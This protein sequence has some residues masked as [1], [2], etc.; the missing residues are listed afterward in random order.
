MYCVIVNPVAGNGKG[1]RIFTDLKNTELYQKIDCIAYVTEYEGHAENIAREIIMKKEKPGCVIVIG[2]DGTLH[3]VMNGLYPEIECVAFISGGSGNDFARGCQIEKDP[4]KAFKQIVTEKKQ[5]DYWIGNYRIDGESERYFVNNIGF[6]FD[7]EITER[8]NSFFIK[9]WCN[10]LGLGM[11]SYVIA[12]ISILFQYKPRTVE[13]TI[14]GKTE[15]ISG[16][17]MVT[18]ANH[19]FYGGGMKIIPSASIQPEFF[20]VLII[21]S[22]SKWKVLA[23]FI[24]VFSGKHVNFKQVSQRMAK[25]LHITT[26]SGIAY[27]ADGIS[28]HCDYCTITKEV[29][30]VPIQGANLVNQYQTKKALH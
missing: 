2:G 16:C 24:T 14:D 28:G 19:P 6:G 4:Q 9:K 29:N 20:P 3:E 13:L 17:W 7:A 5:S 1:E 21:Q 30:S 8:A 11:I 23:L 22:I 25:Q 12:L 18:I 15:Q 10:A 27:Q 26:H